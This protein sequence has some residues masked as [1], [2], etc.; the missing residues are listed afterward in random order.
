MLKLEVGDKIDN[1]IA[2]RTKKNDYLIMK[3]TILSTLFLFVFLSIQEANAQTDTVRPDN[4]KYVAWFAPSGV[5]HMYG[6]MF[7][8]LPNGNCTTYGV[9]FNISPLFLFFSPM[10]F[11]HAIF[12]SDFH[13]A[14]ELSIVDSIDFTKFRKINGLQIGLFDMGETVI[15]GLDI[16]V[17]G[18][19]LSSKINGVCISAIINKNY[20]VNG[21]TIAAI[22]NHDT[23]CNGLQIGIINSSKQ[24]RGV[25]IGL[26]NINQK[27]SLPF[28]NW[29]FSS[30][31]DKNKLVYRH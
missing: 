29:C 8:F 18:G 10:L 13:K 4:K 20:V 12:P 26:W 28:V 6:F 16:N 9:E 17:G 5:T 25:Q 14:E 23:K 7:D 11:A 24:L 1:S 30:K 21:F 22:A 27:R 3:K 2:K 31:F 15:N 19:R